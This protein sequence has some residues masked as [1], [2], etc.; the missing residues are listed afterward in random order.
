MSGA[1]ESSKDGELVK[2]SNIKDLGL[3]ETFAQSVKFAPS[4]RYFAVLGDSDFVVYSYPKFSNA[5]FGQ[6]SDLVWS[7]VNSTSTHT[8]AVR[9]EN[10]T[11]KVYRNFAEYKAFKTTF[12]NE[13]IFGGK[14]LAIKSKDFITFYDWEDFNVIRQIDVSS[15]IK[16]VFWSDDGNFVTITNEESFF[17]L[18]YNEKEVLKAI[19]SGALDEVDEEEG[20]EEAFTFI[21]EYPEVVNSGSWISSEC[22]TFINIRGNI[23]YLIGGRI[24]KLGSADKKQFILGYDGK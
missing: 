13:G 21:D 17:L 10:G 4:G 23:S 24:I 9:L 14:L 18:K 16:N 3:S 22:F 11:V 15:N 1:D 8:Y 20:V 19:T 5:A 7:T 2:P 6:G 12:A